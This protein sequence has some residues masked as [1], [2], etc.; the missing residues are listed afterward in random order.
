MLKRGF[1]GVACPVGVDENRVLALVVAGAVGVE[2][3]PGAF[4]VLAFK[5]VEPPAL[6][7]LPPVPGVELLPA[8]GVVDGEANVL[9]AGLL[10]NKLGPG[11]PEGVPVDAPKRGF[12]PPNK[13]P[14]ALA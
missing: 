7:R 12:A 9:F 4:P 8:A 5:K 6:N 10:P 13:P 3:V 11:V 2:P 14:P 1:A